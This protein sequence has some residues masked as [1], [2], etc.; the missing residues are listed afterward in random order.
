MPAR[1]EFQSKFIFI[2]NEDM[3]GG[4]QHLQAVASR[5]HI[6]LWLTPREVLVRTRHIALKIGALK[7]ALDN[8]GL[9]NKVWRGA[10]AEVVGIC[11]WRNLRLVQTAR[12]GVGAP[13]EITP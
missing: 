6:K 12:T 5:N 1:F 9:T 13:A 2:T 3:N 7:T 4:S 8:K 11:G 10:V